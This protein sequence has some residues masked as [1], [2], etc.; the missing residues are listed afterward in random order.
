MSDI[1]LIDEADHE[2]DPDHQPR[3]RGP[4]RRRHW[5]PALVL[6]VVAALVV[7]AGA[8]GYTK[9]KSHLA[10]APDYTGPGTGKVVFEVKK[11]DSV[12][13]IGTGLRTDGVVKSAAAFIDAAR[14]DSRASSI[15]VGFYDLKKQMKSADALGVLVNPKNQVQSAVTIPEGSRVK[16]I[17]AAIVKHSSIKRS[18]LQA[19]LKRPRSLGLP[20]AAKGNP[21]GYLFPATYTITPD[22][23][24]RDLLRE[25]VA[26]T[27]SVGQ[28]LGIDAGARKVGLTPEQVLTLASILEYEASRTQD[29]PKVAQAIYNRLHK[30]MPLQS[31]ATVSY[32]SSS[33]G[34]LY[35]TNQ[36]RASSSPYNTY[37]HPGLPPGPIGSPGE[38]TIKAALNP[39]PGKQLYWVVVNLKTGE[40]RYANTYAEHLKNVA[41]FHKY[42]QTS[43]AC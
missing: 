20:A 35:T 18:A 43:S 5:I 42:C 6:L 25:M 23:T 33:S 9:L 19:A 12:S 31:D 7:G 27:R 28:A 11:G 32:A 40:T 8:V 22:L 10:T 29:Y 24:A 2:P 34:T 39:S 30:G 36:E 21:E 41:L 4:R 1:G 14:Q 16:A 3:G 13:V 37:K 26:K 15:Q 17:V 38:A